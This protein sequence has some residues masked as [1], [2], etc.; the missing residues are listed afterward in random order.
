MNRRGRVLIVDDSALV[1]AV[2]KRI[3]SEDPDLE[4]VGAARDPYD[5]RD[6]IKA[7]KPDVITLD[8]EMPRMDGI[9]FL[10]ALMAQRPTPVVMVSSLTQIGVQVTLDALDAGAID[11]VAKPASDISRGLAEMA[12]DLREKVHVALRSSVV[13]RLAVAAATVAKTATRFTTSQRIL[14]IG[15]S[16]GGP[17]ALREVL[18]RLP[19]TSPGVV[20]VQHMPPGFT[21]SF[22]ARCDTTCRLHVREAHDGDEIADGVVHIAPGGLHMRV[23]RDGARYRIALSDDALVRRH[24]PSVDV[25]FESLAKTAGRAASAALLTGMGDDGARGMLAMREAGSH[26]VA[27][28]AETSLVFGMPKEAIKL[29]A[30]Q[31]VLPLTAIA[32]ALI[33]A[34]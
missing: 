1:R 8:V 32:D 25:L 12:D 21:S 24:R 30:A 28:D 34:L 5:A 14:A 23:V 20:V 7:L 15:A 31:R 16:T 11:F 22:A 4:V 18:D 29:G 26:T 9:T 17:T 33:D 6:K 3:L 10:R 13:P 27:Q 2:L 19:A